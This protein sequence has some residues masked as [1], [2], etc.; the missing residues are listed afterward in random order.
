[1]KLNADDISPYATALS[2]IVGSVV[3]A[4]FLIVK[5]KVTSTISDIWK[6][7]ATEHPCQVATAENNVCYI[8][9]TESMDDDDWNVVTIIGDT[10]LLDKL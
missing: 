8:S 4:P 1:M 3:V 5:D 10:A 7:L 2:A 9:L 6:N